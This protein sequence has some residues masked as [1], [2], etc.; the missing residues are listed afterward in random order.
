MPCPSI[1][2]CRSLLVQAPHVSL[3]VRVTHADYLSTVR[4]CRLAERHGLGLGTIH[5]PRTECVALLS[6]AVPR[7][8]LVTLT[9]RLPA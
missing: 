5:G 7:W 2:G 1:A 6:A 8:E 9:A 3:G 4:L